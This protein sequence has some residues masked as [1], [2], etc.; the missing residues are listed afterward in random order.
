MRTLFSEGFTKPGDRPAHSPERVC[1]YE[2]AAPKGLSKV[3]AAIERRARFPFEM[4][5]IAFF[6]TIYVIW[7][8][9]DA[10]MLVFDGNRWQIEMMPVPS[11]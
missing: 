2:P 8:R 6:T 1:R 9:P 7:L 4:Q 3:A 10:D 11:I 5:H